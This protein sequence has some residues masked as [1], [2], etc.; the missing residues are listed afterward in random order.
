MQTHGLRGLEGSECSVEPAR[1]LPQEIVD[2][3]RNQWL[4]SPRGG[5][6]A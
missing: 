6:V 4:N 5:E 2:E 3:R 1:Q